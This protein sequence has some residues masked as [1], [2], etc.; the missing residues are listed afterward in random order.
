MIAALTAR[1]LGKESGDR[2]V[3]SFQEVVDALGLLDEVA[4]GAR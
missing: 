4:L 2:K 3:L 1:L